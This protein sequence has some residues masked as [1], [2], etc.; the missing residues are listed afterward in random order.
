G[1]QSVERR[2]EIMKDSRI[3]TFGGAALVLSLLLRVTA[4]SAL[5]DASGGLGA[6]LILIAAASWSRS[7]GIKVLADDFP[8]RTHCAAAAVGRPTQGTMLC[9]MGLALVVTILAFIFAGLPL[10]SAAAALVLATGLAALVAYLARRLIGGQ[11]GDIAGAAQ[12]FA[13]IGFYLGA[14]MALAMTSL[15]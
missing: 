9:A 12:Q 8:A 11:T 4:L 5:T 1:S 6:A 3:G 13:E 15:P 2:L 7:L 10:I 14:V